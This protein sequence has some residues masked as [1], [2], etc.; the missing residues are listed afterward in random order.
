[1]RYKPIHIHWGGESFDYNGHSV[2]HI[3][4]LFHLLM[5][6]FNNYYVNELNLVLS[7]I[8]CSHQERIL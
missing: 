3:V 7:L 5:V 1:M 2:Y 8:D 4:Q 6:A